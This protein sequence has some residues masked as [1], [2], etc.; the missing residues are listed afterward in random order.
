ML[1]GSPNT[2]GT[3]SGALPD[4]VLLAP[5]PYVEE[6]I[7]PVARAEEVAILQVDGRDIATL[8]VGTL[9]VQGALE[10]VTPEEVDIRSMQPAAD[11]MAPQVR[12]G[13][14]SPTIWAKRSSE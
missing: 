2:G 7:L 9:P 11:G 10:L 6:E 4:I 5:T 8:V 13:A 1:R 3:L 12:I 14:R